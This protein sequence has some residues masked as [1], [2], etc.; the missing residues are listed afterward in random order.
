MS[1]QEDCLCYVQWLFEFQSLQQKRNESEQY[2]E[3]Q[4]FEYHNFLKRI[5]DR[6]QILSDK[7][8]IDVP[9]IKS[10][11]LLLN[12]S[13][14]LIL[15]IICEIQF[16]ETFHPSKL[17][18]KL[19]PNDHFRKYLMKLVDIYMQVLEDFD[20]QIF[21]FKSVEK[22][23]SIKYNISHSCLIIEDICI[24]IG[25]R[26]GV[27]DSLPLFYNVFRLDQES[28]LIGN[29]KIL[30]SLSQTLSHI[31]SNGIIA[32]SNNTSMKKL[33]TN[34][35]LE[36]S[37]MDLLIKT[38]LHILEKRLVIIFLF[39]LKVLYADVCFY[40]IEIKIMLLEFT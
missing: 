34:I 1:I 31:C 8:L 19:L 36:L 24:I 11:T 16:Y 4:L 38:I 33:A 40:C 29:T 3:F 21:L 15:F 39:N 17:N 18:L 13:S 5:C 28:L 10:S 6:H 26:L 9:L 35:C 37:F 12:L 22:R 2:Y 14:P 30:S 23:L 27:L 32:I 20:K 25:L 7:V